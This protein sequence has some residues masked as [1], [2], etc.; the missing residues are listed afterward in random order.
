MDLPKLLVESAE[1]DYTIDMEVLNDMIGAAAYYKNSTRKFEEL[2]LEGREIAEMHGWKSKNPKGLEINLDGH[3]GEYLGI[4]YARELDSDCLQIVL[5]KDNYFRH[6]GL[7]RFR[8]NLIDKEFECSIKSHS[9]KEK[10][11]DFIL[12]EMHPY[13]IFEMNNKQDL[14]WKHTYDNNKTTDYD[15][16]I[17]GNI[18]L[19][20]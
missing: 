15:N 10:F 4:H 6:I 12:G 18:N 19:S 1:H 14:L 11:I 16:N 9:K 20:Y 13:S 3:G 2:F 5:A 7:N 17:P 8:N